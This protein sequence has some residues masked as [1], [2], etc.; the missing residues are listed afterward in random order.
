ME[1]E[2]DFR[3]SATPDDAMEDY[4]TTAV[5]GSTSS[6]GRNEHIPI[7]YRQIPNNDA[8]P[9]INIRPQLPEPAERGEG[10]VNLEM[11]LELGYHRLRNSMV[12]NGKKR[13]YC[14]SCFIVH[15]CFAFLIITA[16]LLGGVNFANT[17]NVGTFTSKLFNR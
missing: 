14:V 8:P 1:K 2:T 7:A 10:P 13:K 12:T 5:A 4:S 17:F 6:M 15:A 9:S 3:R 16:A 11:D